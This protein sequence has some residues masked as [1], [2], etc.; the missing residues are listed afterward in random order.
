[1]KHKVIGLAGIAISIFLVLWESLEV[2]Y[3]YGTSGL[4]FYY[5]YYAT[6]DFTWRTIEREDWVGLALCTLW[7][8]F[9]IVPWVQYFLKG[10]RKKS[11]GVTLTGNTDFSSV[12][13]TVFNVSMIIS[14]ALILFHPHD[15]DYYWLYELVFFVVLVSVVYVPWAIV[16]VAKNIKLSRVVE[17]EGMQQ[18][19]TSVKPA[20]W[21]VSLIPFILLAVFVVWF[22]WTDDRYADLHEGRACGCVNGKWG[23]VD[24]KDRVIVPYIYDHASDFSDGRACVGIG[25]KGN[26]KYGYVDRDGNVVIPLVYDTPAEFIDGIA[27]VTRD[28]KQGTIDKD[29]NELIP[30]I[31]DCVGFQFR[32]NRGLNMVRQGDMR[33]FV[34]RNGDVVI[35]IVYEDAE[36][37]FSDNLVRVKLYGKWGYLNR[38][39]DV[40]IPIVYDDAGNFYNGRAEVMLDGE[41][42]YI[43]VKGERN[44]G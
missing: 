40:V 38:K 25:T 41:R 23:Y 18:K 2:L 19:Q 6:D 10:L 28:G 31:Y 32:E 16:V 15:S 14:S 1:M 39:G 22:S 21:I 7:Y 37:F 29:G 17:S 8:F 33:G 36:S 27:Y 4:G 5:Q 34:R 20:Y 35:P 13:F 42:F 11:F 12:F 26:R 3:N 9:L 43:D 24:R 44:N 30:V